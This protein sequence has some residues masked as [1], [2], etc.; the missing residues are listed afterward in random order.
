MTW[1][2]TVAMYWWG[3]LDEEDADAYLK[4]SDHNRS[5]ISIQVERIEKKQRMADGT[6]R[7]YVVAKKRSWSCSWEDLPDKR[8]VSGMMTTVDNGLAATE[9]EIFHGLHDD[10]FPVQFRD[11]ANN[12]E[13]VDV[14][15]TS[16]SKDIKKR[17]QGIDFWDISITLEEC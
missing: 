4:V 11:G 15:I 12:V 9:M 7:R 14:M 5:P 8:N 16:F 2:D 17:G 6:L 1:K 13:Q 3:R 10:A